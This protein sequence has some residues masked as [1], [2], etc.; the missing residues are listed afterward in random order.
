MQSKT[1]VLAERVIGKIK[2]MK[3]KEKREIFHDAVLDTSMECAEEYL[4]YRGVFEEA[5]EKMAKEMHIECN[6]NLLLSEIKEYWYDNTYFNEEEAIAM[7]NYWHSKSH[8]FIALKEYA[9]EDRKITNLRDLRFR[10]EVMKIVLCITSFLHKH[11]LEYPYY[12]Q[13][14]ELLIE[15]ALTE[16]FVMS[17]RDKEKNQEIIKMVNAKKE[18][19]KI[20]L[21]YSLNVLDS[22]DTVLTAIYS[23]D[24]SE[25]FNDVVIEI[26]KLI[27]KEF[28][29]YNLEY[30]SHEYWGGNGFFDA[31]EKVKK[32]I[33]EQLK[34]M[35]EEI[36]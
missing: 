30:V 16:I 2:E 5:V 4:T 27:A 17:V 3:I 24:Y 14:K 13:N 26:E 29:K 32:H 23:A 21:Y 10:N 36:K 20:K 15:R 7:L 31:I 1:N 11:N 18:E 6:W 19:N 35:G 9:D 33:K 8:R 12:G 34:E 28:E 25:I 22:I